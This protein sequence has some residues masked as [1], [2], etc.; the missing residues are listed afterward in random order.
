LGEPDPVSRSA[1][2]NP[3][4]DPR[5]PGFS[6]GNLFG[7]PGAKKG[8]APVAKCHGPRYAIYNTENLIELI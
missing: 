6:L 5:N 8:A 7:F 1:L 3:D 4:P 2:S